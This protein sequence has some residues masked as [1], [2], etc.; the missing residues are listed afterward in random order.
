MHVYIYIYVSVEGEMM[1]HIVFKFSIFHTKVIKKKGIL[2]VT[3][4]AIY[5]YSLHNTYS[6]HIQYVNK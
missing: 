2:S 4:Y 1:V 5:L 3:P 6:L